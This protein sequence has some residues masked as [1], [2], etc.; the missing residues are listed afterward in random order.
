ME[1]PFSHNRATNI[2]GRLLDA[3]RENLEKLKTAATT[4]E[5][6]ELLDF[7]SLEY[8]IMMNLWSAGCLT[9]HALETVG[10]E[11]RFEKRDGGHIPASEFHTRVEVKQ[12][13]VCEQ[14]AFPPKQTD[15]GIL[16]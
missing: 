9:D 1:N 14:V 4:E 10:L 2:I 3:E 5:R 13:N 11:G 15:S 12:E 8:R 6:L 7:S 16:K